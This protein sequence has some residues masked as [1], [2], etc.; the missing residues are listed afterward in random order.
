[1]EKRYK[2][3]Y[4][5]IEKRYWIFDTHTDRFD[6]REYSFNTLAQAEKFI[7]NV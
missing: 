5:G 7:E 6:S 2:V 1:M 3:V 4:C